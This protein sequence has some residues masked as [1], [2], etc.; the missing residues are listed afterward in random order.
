LSAP[1]DPL[2]AIGDGVLL[3]RRR[4][5]RGEKGGEEKGV[6][7][8]LFYFWLRACCPVRFALNIVIYNFYYVIIIISVLGCHVSCSLGY[9]AFETFTAFA[10][11]ESFRLN[12][13][14]L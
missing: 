1:L 2:A 6:A 14:S 8:S 7:S 3:L 4:K 9:T 13:V 11:V 5:G 12:F 10:V